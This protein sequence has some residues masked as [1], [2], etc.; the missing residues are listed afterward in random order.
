MS[1]ATEK[2]AESEAM[3]RS[4]KRLSVYLNDHLADETLAVERVKRAI[5]QN[6]GTRLGTFL[7]LLSW[8][9]EEDRESLLELMGEL[10]VHRK[11]VGLI[12]AGIAAKAGAVKHAT[13]SPLSTLAE[14]ESL[15]LRINGKLDMWNAL[16]S[17][18][19][20]RVHGVDFDELIGR[21][22]RQAEALERRRLAVAA[23]ALS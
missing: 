16:R 10:G 11:S 23:T 20:E 3:R 1:L 9:L 5:S 22:E 17:S 19:G 7:T 18:V 6:N 8:E 14:L 4:A 2:S 15:D 12:R 13:H 21:T